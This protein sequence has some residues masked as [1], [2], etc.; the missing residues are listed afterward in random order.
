MNESIGLVFLL[1]VAAAIFFVLAF[2]SGPSAVRFLKLKRESKLWVR[3]IGA[4]GLVWVSLSFI[5]DPRLGPRPMTPAV[6]NKVNTARTMLG[7]VIIG[8]F[9]AVYSQRFENQSKD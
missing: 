1:V 7:G 8:L 9:I 3:L 5:I 6:W 4:C 2:S